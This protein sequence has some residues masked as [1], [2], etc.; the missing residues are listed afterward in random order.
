MTDDERT[1]LQCEAPDDYG[2]IPPPPR[3]GSEKQ[4]QEIARMWVNEKGHLEVMLRV[5]VW[6]DP[7]VWGMALVDVV[8]HL[9]E[10]YEEK[11]T[12]DGESVSKDEIFKRIVEGFTDELE[13]PSGEPGA[14][15]DS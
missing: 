15:L 11:L 7:A 3:A 13:E 14:Y 1:G 10:A 4:S 2:E 5:G 9:A 8:R 6:H 12:C